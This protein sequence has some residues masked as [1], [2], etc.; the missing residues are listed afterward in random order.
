MVFYILLIS[1][2]IFALY[3]SY[4]YRNI[5]TNI[6]TV[7]MVVGISMVLVPYQDLTT[8][9]LYVYMFF[10]AMALGYGLQAKE[11]ELGS[12]ITIGLMAA[13]ILAYWLW[14]LN[15]WHG[16]VVLFPVITIIVGLFGVVRKHKLKNELGF[17]AILFVDAIAILVEQWMKSMYY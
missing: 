5:A 13:S 7:G 12:K 11:L 3:W 1:V 8:L 16:N 2:S 14:V 17:L 9:G 6:I 4:T 15:H 10:V